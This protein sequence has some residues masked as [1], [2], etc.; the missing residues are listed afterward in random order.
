MIARPKVCSHWSGFDLRGRALDR[1][2]AMGYA[3]ACW[4]SGSD[5]EIQFLALQIAT[6]T[7]LDDAFDAAAGRLDPRSIA[8]LVP[9]RK[10]TLGT[11]VARPG[12]PLGSKWEALRGAL[13]ALDLRL[14]RL[15]PGTLP[16]RR[17]VRAWW[18]HMA[19]QQ[20][21][22]FA[23]ERLLNVGLATYVPELAVASF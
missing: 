21:S 6:M 16:R 20:I 15:A 17:M 14:A 7:A 23:R 12:V 22:V 8:R 9:W 4:P 1:A 19:E 3:R 13:A 5:A 11:W 10:S 2:E 18:R